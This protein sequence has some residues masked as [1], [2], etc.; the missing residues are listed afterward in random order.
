MMSVNVNIYP[1]AR[2]HL[3]NEMLDRYGADLNQFDEAPIYEQTKEIHRLFGYPIDVDIS[4]TNEELIDM[5]ED[6][7]YL[8]ESAVLNTTPTTDKGK[9]PIGFFSPDYILK[10]FMDNKKDYQATFKDCLIPLGRDF[11][12]KS[13]QFLTFKDALV[14]LLQPIKPKIDMTE[15]W[16]EAI[17][18]SWKVK[19]EPIP[20]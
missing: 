18:F 9:D 20:F 2:A 3:L 7:L 12:I 13:M 16:E 4:L 1:R 10:L 5:S 15:F 8:Y 17:R 14:D 19:D 11:V 6:I